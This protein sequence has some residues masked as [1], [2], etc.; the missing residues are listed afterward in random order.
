MD[1]IILAA[2]S[3]FDKAMFPKD[4]QMI[5]IDKIF[6]STTEKNNNDEICVKQEFALQ[7]RKMFDTKFKGNSFYAVKLNSGKKF[8]VID[9]PEFSNMKKVNDNMNFIQKK[10][11]IEFTLENYNLFKNNNIIL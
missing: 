5:I 3:V 1:N 8:A 4:I 6:S 10:C 9:M 2:L 11:G 7:L